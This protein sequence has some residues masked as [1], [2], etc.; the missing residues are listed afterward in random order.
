MRLSGFPAVL[1][2]LALAAIG[3]A[4]SAAPQVKEQVRAY[5]VAHEKAIL[6]EFSQLLSIPNVPTNVPDIERNAAFI[7]G[8]LQKRGFKT[9]LLSAGAGTPPAIYGELKSPGAKRTVVFYVHYD[10]QPAGQTGWRSDPF[11]PVM[12]TAGSVADAKDV[13]WRA[14]DKIDPEWRLYARSTGDDKAPIQAMLSA[15]DALKAA[16]R[17]PGVNIKLFYEGE[18]EI[19]SPNLEKILE[20]NKELLRGDLFVLG[21]GPVHQTGQLQVVFGVRGASAVNLTV[22]GPLRPLHDGHYGNWAPNPAAMLTHLLASMR[23]ESSRILIPGFYDDVRPLTASEKAALAAL[24]D[25]ETQLKRELA[26]GRTES[27]ERLTNAVSLPALNIQGIRVGDVGPRGSNTIY[28]EAQ[29]KIGFRLVPDQTPER[30]RNVTEAFLRAQGWHV[31][32]ADPTP[33]ILRAHPKVVKTEWTLNY[34]AHRSSLD[35]PA[36]KALVKSLERSTGA[37]PVLAPMA[38]GSI[39]MHA[40]ASALKMP[41]MIVGIANHDNNQHGANENIRLQNLWDGIEI[42][43]GMLTDLKW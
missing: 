26:L 27:Q 20:A 29:A 42:Y 10:G 28:P 31:V 35:T 43:A 18:E 9:Q 16:G 4:A 3:Q 19:G 13:D 33:E 39:P 25:V 5:R 17:K 15:L 24:P 14:A 23:D 7:R 22:Y 1:A 11:K 36:A 38:G 21:D 6:E 8:A 41:I 34:P 30:V 37:P 12:R 32:H 2:A 40:F